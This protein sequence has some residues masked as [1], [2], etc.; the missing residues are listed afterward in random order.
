MRTLNWAPFAALMVIT[1]CHAPPPQALGG[2]PRRGS[3]TARF[4]VSYDSATPEF[5]DFRAGLIANRFLDTIA[6]RLNDSLRIPRSITLATAHCDAPNSAYLADSRRVVLCYELFKSLADIFPDQDHEAYLIDGTVM[7]ALM[8]ELGHALVDVLHLPITGR[9]E[10]AVD[11]LAIT[12]LLQQGAAGDSLAFGAVGW[13]ATT[14]QLDQFDSL[15]FADVHPVNLQRVYNILCWVYGRDPARHPEVVSRDLVPDD[16]REQCTD[17][18][19]QMKRSWTE[20]LAPYH[21]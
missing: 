19:L 18:F 5:A 3:D 10:D 20:L 16:R 13:F 17:E 14:N 6:K 4:L 2:P 11:Q 12:L 8:H 7:F 21:R 1:A 9:E 15:T